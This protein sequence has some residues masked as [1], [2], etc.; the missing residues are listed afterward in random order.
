MNT[1]LG[2]IRRITARSG[3]PVEWML[4]GLLIGT[5]TGSGLPHGDGRG[6]K[7][8]PGDTLRSTMDVG[9]TTTISG[10]GRRDLSMCVHTMRRP[11]WPGLAGRDGALVSDSAAGLAMAGARWVS[12]NRSFPGMESAAA[13]STG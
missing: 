9:F 3:L 7:M 12:A 10:D 6:L 5:D 2:E 8:N 13:T 11:W 1:V 4:A